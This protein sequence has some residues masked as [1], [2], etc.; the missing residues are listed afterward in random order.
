MKIVIRN[1]KYIEK[2]IRTGCYYLRHYGKMDWKGQTITTKSELKEIVKKF[3]R[4]HLH[5][6]KDRILVLTPD[7]KVKHLCKIIDNY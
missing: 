7:I 3:F 1:K 4:K 5:T 6:T 2:V